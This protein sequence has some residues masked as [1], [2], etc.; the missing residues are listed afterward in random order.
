[1]VSKSMKNSKILNS[2]DPRPDHLP[3]RINAEE[4]QQHSLA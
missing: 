2:T 4:E 3:T 1:M